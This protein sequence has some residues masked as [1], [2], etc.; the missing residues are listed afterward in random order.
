MLRFIF[1]FEVLLFEYEI[2]IDLHQIFGLTSFVFELKYLNFAYTQSETVIRTILWS[3]TKAAKWWANVGNNFMLN[4]PS[5][6]PVDS[7][8]LHVFQMENVIIRSKMI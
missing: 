8:G 1:S 4:S 6:S 5:N 7:E 3:H 2:Q